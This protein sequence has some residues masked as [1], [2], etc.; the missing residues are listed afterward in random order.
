[1]KTSAAIIFIVILVVLVGLGT[2]QNAE[3][4]ARSNTPEGAVQTF[5]DHVRVHDWDDAFA[6]VQPGPGVD[7][8]MFIRDI[9]GNTGSLKTIS[10]VQKVATKTLDEN[11]T[12]ANVR[13]DLQWSTAVGALHE[14]R[15]FKL[16]N[17]DGSWKLVFAAPQQH[18]L[19]PKP[20]STT[21]LRWDVVQ[22]SSNSNEWGVQNA[23][24][25]RTRIISMNA[26]EYNY[27][28]II[29]GEVVNEDT[30]PGF[31]T[32]NADLIGQDGN[33]LAQESSFDKISHTLL[34]KEVSPFRVDFPNRRLADVKSVRI[35]PT[36]LL[37]PAAAD[38]VV[39]VFDQ[40][41]E[42]D[43]T[44]KSVL[45]GQLANQSGMV[46]N[47]PHVIATFYDK[48]GKVIWVSD[49]YLDQA[50]LPQQSAPFAVDLRDDL[51]GQVQNYRVTVNY[52]NSGRS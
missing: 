23:E 52:Y 5:F 32:I 15:D 35:S 22:S 33:S 3:S 10:T 13:A 36:N 47:I 7:K 27:S 9:G 26:V 17:A 50:I 38:P 44:G 51:A 34:P 20:F 31:V 24:P 11:G 42:K 6:M 30:V 2:V 16:T 4:H 12:E 29:M 18:G 8:Q 41:I 19:E 40:R 1:M 49:G 46:V 37:V 21:Y 25:P 14:T 28:V 45:R 43:S 48:S 39:G